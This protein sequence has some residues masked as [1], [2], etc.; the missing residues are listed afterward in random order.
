M[1]VHDIDIVVVG[2][3]HA[4]CEAALAPAR[5]GLSVWL[6]TLSVDTIGL[7]PCNPSIGG[8][9]KG[10][11]VK[12]I[13]AL[14]G[15]MGRAADASCIQY[16]LLGTSK[17]P[18][19]QGSRMQCD[20]TE[21]SWAM[22]A[23]VEN[24]PGI[25]V[26]QE[27]IDGLII[28]K[29]ACAGVRERSG[30]EVIARAVVLATGT[31]L[32]GTIHVGAVSYAAGRSGEFAS[33]ALA[34]QLKRLGLSWGRFKT[35]TP[36]RV[37]GAT[38]NTD[39]M[40]EDPGSPF[41]RPFSLRSQSIS[42]PMRSCFRTYTSPRTHHIIRCN[43]TKSPLYSGAIKG[44]PARYCPSLEDKVARFPDRERHAVVAEPEGL[45]T[46]ELY[47]KGLGNSLP[48][49]LQ[50]ELVR[51]VPGLEE[52]EIVRPAYAIEYDYIDPTGLK[53]TL[54]TKAIS[55]LYLAGQINGT[56][57]YEEAAAQGLWAGINAAHSVMGKE[58]LVLDRS[59]AYMGVMVD[60]L[61]TRGV[62]EPYR[63]FTS[64]A[65]YRLLLREDNAP[66]RLLRKGC[67]LGLISENSLRDLE[68]RIELLK[69]Q[70]AHA[71]AISVR[72]D[73]VNDLIRSRGATELREA[74][75]AA[76]LLKRPEVRAEDLIALGILDR[77]LDRDTVAKLEIHLKYE[78]Y[79][80]RQTRE[81]GQFRR[82][83]KISIPEDLDFHS[84]QGLS[85]EIR[86]RLT[87]LRPRSLGQVSRIPG[88]TPAAL[89]AV[90][91]RLRTR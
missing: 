42:R 89:T 48:A 25:L 23:A 54:E 14:G 26:R 64:R 43:L 29:G 13:D 34:S 46:T 80:E 16:K 6:Y 18:A 51:S 19:V 60:D 79:I 74:V 28:R 84:I 20:R 5:M 65:E 37:K 47:L 49:D 86:E 41:I 58:P 53:H 39:A 82:M 8:L 55:G 75:S 27:M 35:G 21:Y 7:M 77:D 50:H 78:G 76:R 44:T 24:E 10:H 36:P 71:E 69:R 12:E 61:V 38:V 33:T 66:E 32:D 11:L 1:S 3:G 72:P 62:S 56:S 59:E 91:V 81:A 88:I 73:L 45:H 31:F 83:E 70:I 15:E 67:S 30:Y 63:M 87:L 68:E 22:R 85:R 90:M 40:T 4:G 17:G 52:A 2:A 57:G 9:G